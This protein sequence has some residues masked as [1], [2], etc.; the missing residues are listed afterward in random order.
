[1]KKKT[2]KRL[3]QRSLSK[4]SAVA[5]SLAVMWGMIYDGFTITPEGEGRPGLFL[6]G[7]GIVWLVIWLYAQMRGGWDE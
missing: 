1:M 3:I 4:A 2:L 7:M 6:M 5:A